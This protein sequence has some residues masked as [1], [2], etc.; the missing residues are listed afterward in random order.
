MPVLVLIIF[1]EYYSEVPGSDIICDQR[2]CSYASV[3]SQKYNVVSGERSSYLQQWSGSLLQNCTEKCRVFTRRSTDSHINLFFHR[4]PYQ[5]H[6]RWH[7][8]IIYYENSWTLAIRRLKY[9][10]Q[11]IV[12]L[13]SLCLKLEQLNIFLLEH[14]NGTRVILVHISPQVPT[15]IK[16]VTV[17]KIRG[18]VRPESFAGY[19]FLKHFTLVCQQC[20]VALYCCKHRILLAIKG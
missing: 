7:K 11:Y 10:Q 16:R 14:F 13:C 4:T 6:T 12:T 15:E 9:A 3:F 20:A 8:L 5:Y 2:F 19:Y 18:S 17:A 1:C